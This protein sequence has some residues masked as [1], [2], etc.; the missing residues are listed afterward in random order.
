[1]LERRLVIILFMFEQQQLLLEYSYWIQLQDTVV[2]SATQSY[3]SAIKNDLHS[4]AQVVILLVILFFL[5]AR[6]YWRC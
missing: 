2:C 5:A 1:M 4:P 6:R 3:Y